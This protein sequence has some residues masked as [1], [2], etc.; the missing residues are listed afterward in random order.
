MKKILLLLLAL[1]FSA[2]VLADAAATVTVEKPFARKA[3]KAQRNS[4]AFMTL[5]N[6]GPAVAI[7][8]AESPV[9]EIVELHTHIHDN[10]VMR[11]RKI[12][13]IELP[14]G[15]EVTLKPGGLHV[16]LLGLKQD[17]NEGDRVSVTLKF[18]DGSRK[19]IE[20]PVRMVMRP[21]MKGMKHDMKGM[22]HSKMM[23]MQAH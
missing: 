21:K 3:M 6:N 12:D 19:T 2:S 15:G 17:L 7:V 16:M 11:M 8:A 23:K 5:R 20:A 4:A 18:S 9:A 13:K 10:G 1:A 22:D 14:A